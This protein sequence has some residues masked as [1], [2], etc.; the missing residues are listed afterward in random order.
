MLEY[1][2][3][4]S[5]ILF[6]LQTWPSNKIGAHETFFLLSISFLD[7]ITVSTGLQIERYQVIANIR[8]R[9]LLAREQR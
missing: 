6:C 7:K 2:S 4:L 9:Y 5:S 8:L 1:L 3:L